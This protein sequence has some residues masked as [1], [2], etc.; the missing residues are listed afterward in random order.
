VRLAVR[1]HPGAS[2]QRV[3]WDG[4]VAHVWVTAAA[5][6]GAAN[7]AVVAAVAAW[8]EIAPSRV[9]MLRGRRSRAKL[10]DLDGVSGLPATT[11]R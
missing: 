9:V 3:E 1:A 7:R 11:R 4:A 2:R 6:D 10:L 5:A 8:L